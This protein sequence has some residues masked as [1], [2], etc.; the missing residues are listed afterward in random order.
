MTATSPR[1]LAAK[2]LVAVLRDDSHL[3][4]ALRQFT[5][6]E[7]PLR[8]AALAQELCYGTLRFQ[9][10]LEFW[11]GKLLERPLKAGETEV[12]A[13]LLLGLYQLSELRVPAHAAVKETAEAARLLGKPW[14][15]GLVNAVLR[16][17]QRERVRFQSELTQCD[18]ALYAHA[19]WLIER[20]RASWPEN[21]QAILEA[22]NI[23]PPLTLRAN[24][25]ITGRDALVL[26][27][28][29][30]GIA[31]QACK[32]STDGLMVT[33][34]V[35]VETLPGFAEGKFS[36]QDEA[37]QLAAELLE[38]QPGMRV[39]D[40]CAAP[41]GKTCHLLERYPGMGE[42]LALDNDAARIGKIHD[43]LRRLGLKA[44]VR[45]ADV[46]RPHD[47]WDGRPFERILLDAPCSA[48][49]VIRRHPD[50]KA[51]RR[52][53]DI[54]AATVLQAQL[55]TAL[56]PLLASGGKLLY[57]TCSVLNE[58]NAFQMQSFLTMHPDARSAELAAGWGVNA[59]PGRQILT[60]QDRMDGFYYAC[61]GKT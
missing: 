25:R 32:F 20:I 33:A 2:V 14:A 9:P 23:R 39:L 48:S 46:A 29:S 35:N 38:V 3:N 18:E 59:A 52:P 22:N 41:G 11:L 4:T 58:E 13:L 17:F 43:N 47:W 21:W 34:P 42:L 6:P 31:A 1:A 40:A 60:G 56:W 36:V 53:Q 57:A 24:Q 55:L 50:I 7:N 44:T 45:T 16:R 12:H 28:A 27:F 19:R 30:A 37:A 49:G 26:E 5:P 15:V 10:R 51:R 61:L 8:D 54:T